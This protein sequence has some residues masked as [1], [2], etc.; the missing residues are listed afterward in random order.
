MERSDCLDIRIIIVCPSAQTSKCVMLSEAWSIPRVAGRAAGIE[1]E[2]RHS[3]GM[4][5]RVVRAVSWAIRVVVE[6][7]RVVTKDEGNGEV[8]LRV[9][10]NVGVGGLQ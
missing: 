7:D 2:E 10:R 8:K 4:S 6:T 1:P 9:G 5:L 3:A